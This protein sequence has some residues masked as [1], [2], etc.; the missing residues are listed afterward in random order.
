MNPKF[1]FVPTHSFSIKKDFYSIVW[2]SNKDSYLKGTK[3]DHTSD[4]QSV[5]WIGLS[6]KNASTRINEPSWQD[7]QSTTMVELPN[8]SIA[9]PIAIQLYEYFRKSRSFGS[10]CFSSDVRAF[11]SDARTV[12]GSPGTPATS[13]RRRIRAQQDTRISCILETMI[14]PN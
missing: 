8:F 13:T 4:T 1:S 14:G 11:K 7:D 9:T 5:Y 10:R 6:L 2:D 3:T 12:S